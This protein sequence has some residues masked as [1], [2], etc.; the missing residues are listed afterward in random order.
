MSA[1]P[2]LQVMFSRNNRKTDFASDDHHMGT[3]PL[4]QTKENQ[5]YTPELI[6][7]KKM[8]VQYC[9]LFLEGIVVRFQFHFLGLRH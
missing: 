6:T 4:L 5:R 1:S 9:R 3:V 2:T 8:N 7:K